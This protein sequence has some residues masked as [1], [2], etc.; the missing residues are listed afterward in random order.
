MTSVERTGGIET[1]RVY[2][3]H[4]VFAS[5]LCISTENNA[6]RMCQSSSDP[7]QV[8]VRMQHLVKPHTPH[9]SENKCMYGTVACDFRSRALTTATQIRTIL[10]SITFL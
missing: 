3:G 10:Q 5:I 6:P 9:G 4:P 1:E 8:V 7:W 2:T